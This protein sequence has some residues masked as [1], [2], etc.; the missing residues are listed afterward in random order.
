MKRVKTKFPL[1]ICFTIAITYLYSFVNHATSIISKLSI[2][3]EYEIKQQCTFFPP[4]IL[5]Y[6]CLKNECY[7]LVSNLKGENYCISSC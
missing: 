5:V 3:H 1:M 6:L 7:P 4:N 2:L